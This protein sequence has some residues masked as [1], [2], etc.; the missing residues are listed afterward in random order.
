[1]YA[2]IG[3]RLGDQ[4]TWIFPWRGIGKAGVIDVDGK[5]IPTLRPKAQAFASARFATLLEH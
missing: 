3:N 1:M 2:M 4:T 5:L